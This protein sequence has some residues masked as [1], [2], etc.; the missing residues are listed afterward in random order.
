[1]API[2]KYPASVIPQWILFD[3]AAPDSSRSC[4]C[5]TGMSHCIVDVIDGKDCTPQPTGKGAAGLTV[6]SG[7]MFIG[8]SA[9]AADI[10]PSNKVRAPGGTLRLTGMATTGAIRI[11]D[12]LQALNVDAT[13]NLTFTAVESMIKGK[14]V[15]AGWALTDN[16]GIPRGISASAPNA[17][18]DPLCPPLRV[19]T[20]SR[21]APQ[22]RA[23]V[24]W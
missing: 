19:A 16:A 13:G 1:M 15:L 22:T 2:A 18:T 9:G 7:A 4:G 3:L 17:T 14:I 5:G 21:G 6:S 20:A 8:M 23:E 24:I 12:F 10:D 11:N